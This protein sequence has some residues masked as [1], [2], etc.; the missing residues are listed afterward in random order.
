MIGLGNH[1]DQTARQ[2]GKLARH[3]IDIV[4]TMTSHRLDDRIGLG[5]R[6]SLF[7]HYRTQNSARYLGTCLIMGNALGI[8]S[9]TADIMQKRCSV[10]HVPRKAKAVLKVDDPRHACHIQQV[11]RTVAAVSTLRLRR[12]DSSQV[13]LKQG[14]CPNCVDTRHAREQR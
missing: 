14:V 5:R 13:F 10:D 2:R 3:R 7:R 1:A 4:G 12:L 11:G 6:E 8:F 9:R